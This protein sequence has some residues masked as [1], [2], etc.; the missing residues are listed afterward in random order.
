MNRFLLL[1]TL[2]LGGLATV[3]HGQPSSAT[4]LKTARRAGPANAPALVRAHY[5]VRGLLDPGINNMIAFA[6]KI[7][8]GWQLHQSFTRVWNGAVPS[9]VIDIRLNAPDQRSAIEYLPEAGYQG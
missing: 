2:L 1:C 6:F 9:N 8:R 5:E 7:P 3:C 4:L